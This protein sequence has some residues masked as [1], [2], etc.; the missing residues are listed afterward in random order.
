[1]KHE[2][3][4]VR[5]HHGAQKMWAKF[6]VDKKCHS[7]SYQLWSHVLQEERMFQQHL[8]YFSEAIFSSYSHKENG[9][10]CVSIETGY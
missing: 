6:S 3:N 1:M 10:R 8:P 4:E 7:S 2:K 5:I 9:N